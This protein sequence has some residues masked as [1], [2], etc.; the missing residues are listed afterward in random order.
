LK[1]RRNWGYAGLRRVAPGLGCGLLALVFAQRKAAQVLGAGRK[2][3]L[4]AAEIINQFQ[5]FRLDAQFQPAFLFRLFR[6]HGQLR[7][8]VFDGNVRRRGSG[9]NPGSLSYPERYYKYELTGMYG[10]AYRQGINNTGAPMDFFSPL[11]NLAAALLIG[12]NPIWHDLPDVSGLLA[13]STPPAVEQRAAEPA[14]P[15]I[16]SLLALPSGFRAPGSEALTIQRV[17]N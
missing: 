5:P 14:P 10:N 6:I 15:S 7:S 17:R 16:D 4:L 11:A 3:F 2:V 8:V 9:V 13:S 12:P 1:G